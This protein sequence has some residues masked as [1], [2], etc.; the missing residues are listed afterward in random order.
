MASPWAPIPPA[1]AVSFNQITAE[2][3]FHKKLENEFLKY[4]DDKV[5]ENH[6]TFE[7]VE[8]E[9]DNINSDRVIAQL[10]QNQFNDEYDLML[11]RTEDKLNRGAKVGISFANFRTNPNCPDIIKQIDEDRDLDHFV[12]IEKEYASIPRCGYKK[13][14]AGSEIVTKHD[15]LMSS[16]INACRVLEFPPGIST[17]D[18][19][20]F[21][22]KL[23][24]NVFNSLRN[25][26]HAHCA[27]EKAKVRPH[28]QNQSLK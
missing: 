26:S 10:L 8:I 18:T 1:E 11:K 16:R 23:N 24:N 20:G 9:D 14:N 7:D 4:A 19:G 25:H 17:G 21:D 22:V 12:E 5:T 28:K 2:Q 3:S 15:I 13:S 6:A 27:R